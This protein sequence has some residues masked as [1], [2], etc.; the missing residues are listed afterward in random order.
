MSSHKDVI[1]DV[2]SVK[3]GIRALRDRWG[4]MQ[5]AATDWPLR[6]P[7][8]AITEQRKESYSSLSARARLIA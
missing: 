8:A 4:K 1:V 5:S 7:P 6:Q 2:I 3:Q